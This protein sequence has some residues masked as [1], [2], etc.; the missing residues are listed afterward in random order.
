VKRAVAILCV[1]LLF[2]ESGC[3]WKFGN[4]VVEADVRV[5]EKAVDLALE[6]AAAKVQ[7]ELQMRGLQVTMNPDRD[8]VRVVSRTK[9][10]DQFTVV[11]SRARTDSGKEQTKVRVEWGA[12]P[13]REL[14][15]GLLVALAPAV[16]QAAH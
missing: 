14:W 16:I 13:D 10:G 11:L 2:L 1:G 7:K 9:T 15:L 6:E 12:S 8:A 3:A 4:T 5:D